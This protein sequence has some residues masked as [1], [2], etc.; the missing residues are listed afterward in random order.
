MRAPPAPVTSSSGW[1]SS[2]AWSTG[3]GMKSCTWKASDS[4]SSAIGIQGRSTWRT[5]TRWLATP[6]TTFLCEKRVC[7]QS[8]LMAWATASTSMTSPSRTAPSGRATWPNFSSV[9][10][11]LPND[12]SAARTP[13]VPMS[14]PMAVR[15]AT[16]YPFRD[17]QCRVPQAGA[18]SKG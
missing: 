16:T 14:R 5:I 7:D 6:M 10:S 1:K 4:F 8:C 18:A 12:S 9:T 15:P 11:P 17:S 3:I 2:T 13:E